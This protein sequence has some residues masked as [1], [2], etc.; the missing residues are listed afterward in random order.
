MRKLTQAEIDAYEHNG[1]VQVDNVFPLRDLA[2]I[3]AE[4]TRL[5]NAK[6][7]REVDSHGTNPANLD[8]NL[9]L[10]L[11]L[12]SPVTQAMCEDERILALVEG[13]VKPG[14]AI[15]SAKMVEKPPFDNTLCHWHQDD[16]YYQQNSLSETRMSIWIPLQDTSEE[17]ACL[18]VVPGSHK[19]GL[20]AYA[21]IKTGFCNLAFK[22]ANEP[23]EGAVPCPIPAGSVILFHAL[24]WHRSLGNQ[25]AQNRRSFIVSYQDALALRGNKD[26]HKVLIAA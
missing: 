5:K 26:Q 12:R 24:T 19:W 18:W 1:Y 16:A 14:V 4:I 23:I 15:Y 8:K 25:T 2:D 20:Q 22:E 11:G 13:I 3:D 21:N 7:H 17:M 6:T 10:R 9:M